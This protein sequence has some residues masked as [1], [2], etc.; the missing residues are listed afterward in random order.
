MFLSYLSAFR[1]H[2][3]R[4]VSRCTLEVFIRMDFGII[5][6]NAA[7]DET[8]TYNGLKKCQKVTLF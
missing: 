4:A 2:S 8:L 5:M 7:L 6:L 3:N 1:V